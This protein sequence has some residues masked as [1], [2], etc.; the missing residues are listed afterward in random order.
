MPETSRCKASNFASMALNLVSMASNLV[1][2]ASN[3]VSGVE[4]GVGVEPRVQSVEPGFEGQNADTQRYK[5]FVEIALGD[6]AIY[7]L[8]AEG[9]RDALGVSGFNAGLF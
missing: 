4:L 8:F 3:L 6:D 2:M 9:A 5:G 7:Q 1:S